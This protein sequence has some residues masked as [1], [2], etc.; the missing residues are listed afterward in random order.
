MKSALRFVLIISITLVVGCV[1][2]TLAP[3]ASQVRVTRSASDVASCKAVGNVGT[4]LFKSLEDAQNI[5]VGLG[6]NALLITK[7]NLTG[8]LYSGIAYNCPQSP[9]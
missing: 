1:T 4:D 9:K 7:E 6:G 8:T 5:T 3:G 2:S